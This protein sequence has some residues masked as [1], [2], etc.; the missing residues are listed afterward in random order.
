M[1]SWMIGICLNAVIFFFIVSFEQGYIPFPLV[2][3]VHDCMYGL[4]LIQVM[5]WCVADCHYTCHPHCQ[6][7]VRLDCRGESDG[8]LREA[9]GPD[10]E[11]ESVE[12]VVGLEEITDPSLE[13]LLQEVSSEVTTST[14]ILYEDSW[15]Y[16]TGTKP[17]HPVD[18]ASCCFRNWRF[19]PPE[20]ILILACC[21]CIWS[22]IYRW[23][24]ATSHN[25]RGF[26]PLNLTHNKV[27]WISWMVNGL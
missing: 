13:P 1:E 22:D 3:P 17:C 4:W 12:H 27:M 9:A 10:A 24:S 20:L 2:I 16:Y 8:E 18:T 11:L 6:N 7:L 23:H 14:Y 21:C 26:Q 25:N 5:N 19:M 15:N